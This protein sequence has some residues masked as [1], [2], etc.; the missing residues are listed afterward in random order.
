MAEFEEADLVQLILD[1]VLVRS[2][3]SLFK[4]ELY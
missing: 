2:V 4:M 3:S 1:L